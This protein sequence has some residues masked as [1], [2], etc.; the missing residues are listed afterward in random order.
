MHTHFEIIVCIFSKARYPAARAA[1][2]TFEQLD[3]L[4]FPTTSKAE[5]CKSSDF[6]RVFKVSDARFLAF[7]VDTAKS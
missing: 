3:F 6:I 4:P 2:A 5:K 7:E 1:D